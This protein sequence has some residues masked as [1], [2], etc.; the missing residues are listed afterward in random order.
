MTF[1][2]PLKFDPIDEAR[3]QWVA[4]G[5]PEAA[6]G[7]AVVTSVFRAQRIYLSRIDEVLRPYDLSFSRLEL[8]TLLSFTSTGS[9]PMSKMGVRLQVHPTSVTSTVDRLVTQGF[10]RRLAHRTDRRTTLAEIRPAGRRIVKR[11][12]AAL[13]EQVFSDPGMPPSD[14]EKLFA[15]LRALRVA[16]QDFEF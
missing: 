12:I 3:R 7:M 8:L 2:K 16:E 15:I 6:S 5:W 11:A 4:R 10:V 13:N 14:A 9:M 1:S